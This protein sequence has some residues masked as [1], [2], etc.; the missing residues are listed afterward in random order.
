MSRKDARGDSVPG[1]PALFAALE[2]QGFLLRRHPIARVNR[3]GQ[4]VVRFLM[5]KDVA[6]EWPVDIRI[7]VKVPRPR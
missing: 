6:G 5:V 7:S 3:R 4:R 2:A 1:T